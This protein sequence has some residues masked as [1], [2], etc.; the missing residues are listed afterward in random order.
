M[1]CARRAP[2]SSMNACASS[3]PSR[4]RPRARISKSRSTR[5][6]TRRS[7]TASSARLSSHCRHGLQGDPLPSALEAL[8]L[9]E[10][11]LES[12]PRLPGP[13]LA[14][15]A[16]LHR[17]RRSSARARETD[18]ARRS[19]H[20][21]GQRALLSVERR[22]SCVPRVRRD[23]GARDPAG[24]DG[25]AVADPRDHGG[26]ASEAHRGRSRAHRR[27]RHSARP[28]ARATKATRASGSS[29]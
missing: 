8:D 22:A 2:H 1:G 15:Q 7:P 24:F 13:A 21:R 3:A 6:G 16:A 17:R 19:D 18:R 25:D 26:D 14:R 12:G 29:R 5:V 20:R 27:A 4:R 23:S 9:L 28:R 11:R 10:Y